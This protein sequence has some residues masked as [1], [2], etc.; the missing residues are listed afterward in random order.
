MDNINKIH[1]LFPDIDSFEIKSL[2]SMLGTK[3]SSNL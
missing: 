1:P 2:V 3:L